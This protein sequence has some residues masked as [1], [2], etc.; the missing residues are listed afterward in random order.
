MED[1]GRRRR[2]SL[3]KFNSFVLGSNDC[4]YS[5]IIS[6]TLDFSPDNMWF[7]F[8]FIISASDLNRSWQ[9]ITKPFSPPL[10][11]LLRRPQGPT[12]PK[13]PGGSR[14]RG[15][16][17]HTA[18]ITSVADSFHCVPIRPFRIRGGS[19][20]RYQGSVLRRRRRL[21]NREHYGKRHQRVS[22]ASGDSG[23]GVGSSKCRQ[24]RYREDGGHSPE[25]TEKAQH[26]GRHPPRYPG[27]RTYAP[28]DQAGDP[29][30]R[31]LARLPTDPEGPP[32]RTDEE[33]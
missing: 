26:P 8:G 10:R 3:K 25:Q 1:G 4:F 14:P 27:R 13:Q 20:P 7:F 12:G 9:Q 16:H 30:A 24:L 15:G 31:S 33:G 5:E 23:T 29:M 28:L 22:R 11:I 6:N 17:R 2:G 19:G 18:G 21:D 32:R